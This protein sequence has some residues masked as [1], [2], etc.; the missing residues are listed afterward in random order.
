MV[1]EALVGTVVLNV[2]NVDGGCTGNHGG[3]VADAADSDGL[4]GMDWDIVCV[5]K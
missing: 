2:V 1:C 4:V 5:A 3:D